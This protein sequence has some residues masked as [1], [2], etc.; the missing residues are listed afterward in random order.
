MVPGTH[1]RLDAPCRRELVVV[2]FN[3][4]TVYRAQAERARQLGYHALVPGLDAAAGHADDSRRAWLAVARAWDNTV[5]DTRG[6]LSRPAAEAGH[7]ALWTGRLAYADPAWTPARRPSHAV[8][9][10]ANLAPGPAALTEIASALHYAADS[11]ARAARTDLDTVGTA[12]RAGRLYVT[13]RSLPAH[14]DVPRP[15]A[16]APRDRIADA[17]AVYADTADTCQA[18]LR[19]AGDVAAA[20]DAPSLV[21][22][23]ADQATA[24]PAAAPRGR[25]EQHLLDLGV[26]DAGLLRQGVELDQQTQQVLAQAHRAEPIPRSRTPGLHPDRTPQARQPRSPGLPR[27]PPTSPKPRAAWTSSP[28]SR[29]GKRPWAGTTPTSSGGPPCRTAKA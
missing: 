25:L 10:P 27:R 18:M 3:T 1:R 7:L 12:G 5:T 14:Y 24:H 26:R 21:L 6:Y 23:A 16:G 17:L 19:S 28:V 22:S 20:V 8:R 9:D 29:H 13:T 15:Y 2:S 4:E 11:L